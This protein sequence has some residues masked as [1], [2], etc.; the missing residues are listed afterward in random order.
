MDLL[1]KVT[2]TA[3]GGAVVKKKKKMS[4]AQDFAVD[5]TLKKMIWEHSSRR[6]KCYIPYPH[7]VLSD[8]KQKYKFAGARV[9][10]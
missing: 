2:Q 8:K 5:I 3:S 1:S 10:L 9:S 4:N 7:K 6:F